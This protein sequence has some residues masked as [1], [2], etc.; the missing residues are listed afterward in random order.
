[1]LRLLGCR[2]VAANALTATRPHA[3]TLG[4]SLPSLFVSC[5]AMLTTRP[6]NSACRALSDVPLFLPFPDCT[7]LLNLTPVLT[8]RGLSVVW[9]C[10]EPPSLPVCLA[11]L[12]GSAQW[13]ARPNFRNLSLPFLCLVT[14]KVLLF[15][16]NPRRRR[17]GVC[18]FPFAV[19]LLLRALA[20]VDSASRT[21]FLSSLYAV[22]FPAPHA[23]RGVQADSQSAP[24]GEQAP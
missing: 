14:V 5:R 19:C 9:L 22:P 11:N 16:G 10:D 1:M 8:C 2:S 3:C 15:F 17:P 20:D 21:P 23:R 4:Q 18:I 6:L 13:F 12:P 24:V 7:T